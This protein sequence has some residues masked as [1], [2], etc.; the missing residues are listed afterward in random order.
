MGAHG[1]RSFIVPALFLAGLAI[2][3]AGPAAAQSS[4]PSPATPAE[5]VAT[6]QT[7][8]DAIL[9]V[10]NTEAN[11]IRSILSATRAHAQVELGRAQ[12]AIKAGDA[13]AAQSA[14]ENLA[15]DVV[16][17]PRVDCPTVE[18]G[19]GRMKPR[20][21][22]AAGTKAPLLEAGGGGLAEVVAERGQHH[23]QGA[24][25]VEIGDEAGG[26]VHA[27]EGVRPHV[28][29][30]MPLGILGRVGQGQKLGSELG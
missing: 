26:L 21:L 17:V 1:S 10:K 2:L 8:A 5:M 18:K 12:K 13:K 20:L 7:L 19:R 11:L 4:A 27:L 23:G 30:G 28:A 14:V 25:V 22:V 29:F 3:C 9:A 15:A 24:R 16:A 6:Y